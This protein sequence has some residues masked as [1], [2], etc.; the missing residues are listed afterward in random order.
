MLSK[1]HLIL[2]L[3]FLPLFSCTKDELTRPVEAVLLLEMDPAEGAS[4]NDA[5]LVTGGQFLIHEVGFDGYRES[6]ENYFFTRNF[7]GGH[8]IPFSREQPGQIMQFEM[9]QG[10]YSRIDLSMA[11]PAGNDAA[12]GQDV[13]E[14]SSV[15]GGIELWGTYTDSH[16]VGIPFLFIYVLPDNF[17]FTAKGEG[18]GQQVVVKGKRQHRA[19]LQFQPQRW[20]DLINPRMLQSGK[21]SLVSG[22]PTVVI[23]RSQN[24]AIYNLLVNRIEQSALFFFD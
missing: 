8:T 14:R 13:L 19:R 5:L 15:T 6:G 23:S 18:G 9:P 10:I 1:K 12:S 16:G 24:E 3:A 20:M 4:E 11:L 21:L 7:T 22:Q 2:F 17:R